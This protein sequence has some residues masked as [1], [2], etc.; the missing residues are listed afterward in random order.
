[1]S[2]PI[3][4]RAVTNTATATS[5]SSG[6]I[7]LAGA[8]SG[9][10]AGFAAG[11]L[12][13]GNLNSALSGAFNGAISGGLSGYYGS[14]YPFE[15]V[16]ANSVAGGVSSATN[17]GRFEDGFKK[18]AINSLL[19]YGNVQMRQSQIASSLL[20]K[21]GANDG[22]GL[23]RGLFGDLFKLA[24]GRYDENAQKACSLL[25]CRQ[26]G[27]GSI[28]GWAYDAGGFRDMVL[29]SYA[30]PHDFANAPHWYNAIGNIRTELGDQSKL[31]LDW[32]TNYTTSLIFATPFALAAIREQTGYQA[33]SLGR[34]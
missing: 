26:N 21:T 15:R 27:R 20:D 5:V 19:T 18:A 3:Y 30:G 10:A 28:F 2:D 13:G 24:G 4:Y 8:G 33:Y 17:G 7:S 11:G 31:L 23:S 32:T 22:T 9:A 14:K 6:T 1:M 29:E 12:Q 16:L 25:G 34:R